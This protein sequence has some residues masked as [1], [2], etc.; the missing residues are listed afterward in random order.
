MVVVPLGAG[1]G[2]G[3]LNASVGKTHFDDAKQQL[4]WKIGKL[5]TKDKSPCLSGSLTYKRDGPPPSPTLSAFF[6][7][8]MYSV[9]GVKVSGLSIV[10]TVAKPYKGVRTIA[11][12]G[13]FQVCLCR[14]Q[15]LMAAPLIITSLVAGAD[16]HIT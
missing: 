9:S 16:V 11:K 7:V 15:K 1:I 3:T 14:C 10:N 13:R 12:A 5:Q 6:R 2:V 8:P 4:L